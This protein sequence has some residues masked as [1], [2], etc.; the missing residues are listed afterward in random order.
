MTP[1]ADVRGSGDMFVGDDANLGGYLAFQR[2][3][4]SGVTTYSFN[5]T[6]EQEAAIGAAADA[7]G[8][9]FPGYCADHVSSALHGIGPFKDLS[10]FYRPGGLGSALSNLPGVTIGQVP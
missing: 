9:A 4:G 1:G 8:G 5:T 3:T 10:H 6:P 2:S 7:Q